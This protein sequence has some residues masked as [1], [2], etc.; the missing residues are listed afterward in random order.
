[1]L[2]AACIAAL[3]LSLPAGAE[4]ITL[5]EGNPG[6]ESDFEINWRS[7]AVVG[8]VANLTLELRPAMPLPVG[9]TLCIA[10]HWSQPLT[11]QND[12][13]AD[14]GYLTLDNADGS[15]LSQLQAGIFGGLDS[16]VPVPCFELTTPVSAE[17]STIRLTA[18]NLQLPLQVTDQF[19][20]GAYLSSPGQMSSV[21]V[22]SNSLTVE[23]GSRNRVTA[24]ASAMSAPGTEIEFWIRQEDKWGN[25]A[26]DQP[27]S[28]DLI[29]NDAYSRR[30]QV[31]AAV[32]RIPG[33]RFERPGVY[34]LEVRTGGGGLRAVT[35]P[36]LVSAS[37]RTVHWLNLGATTAQ[38]DGRRSAE[39]NLRETLGSYDSTLLADH[40]SAGNDEF[41]AAMDG[42]DRRSSASWHAASAASTGAYLAIPLPEETREL[43]VALAEQPS[44]FRRLSAASLGLTQV[45]APDADYRW[46]GDQASRRGYRTGF[47][48]ISH[49]HKVPKQHLP[50]YTGVWLDRGQ[51]VMDGLLSRQTFVSVGER[52]L[53][54]SNTLAL[55]LAPER[56]L[57]LDVLAAT[58]INAVH[59]Y[60]NGR[61]LSSKLGEARTDG[62]FV[63]SFSSDN[64]PYSGME[65]RPRN[66]REWIGY[67]NASDSALEIEPQPGVLVRQ[68]SNSSRVDFYLKTHGHRRSLALQLPDA[69]PD[70]VLETGLAEVYEDTAWLPVD[71]LP[72]R[73]PA[74]LYQIPLSEIQRGTVRESQVKGYGDRI[75]IRPATQSLGSQLSFSFTDSA[76]P[77]LGD[78]YY[79]KVELANGAYAYGS[80]AFVEKE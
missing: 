47:V 2:A 9:S 67:F 56:T 8:E 57:R 54:Q 74:V 80:P 44:D 19:R 5:S 59:L 75:E 25:L 14:N 35:N 62:A 16:V 65:S 43:V 26:A 28:L 31:S 4:E 60:K 49:T 53:L 42:T 15:P 10:P 76:A 41:A 36:V 72:Q 20:F 39:L 3:L 55:T 22:V 52:V 24:F 33:I 51:T 29:I 21:L 69:G 11:L 61:L 23:A 30:I 78:Y 17:G 37:D 1:M 34:R 64:E 13:P 66:G 77:R 12:S 68:G 70:T 46:L 48:G 63:A 45:V 40:V 73:M 71:R 79:F 32:E 7:A 18:S 27:L 38:T 6:A 58:D 50:V